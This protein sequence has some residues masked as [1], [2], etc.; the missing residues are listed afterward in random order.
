MVGGPS[1]TVTALSIRGNRKSINM[2]N[3]KLDKLFGLLHLSPEEERKKRAIL[4]RDMR[5]PA[6]LIGV[7]Q[8]G[9]G[10]T[11]LLRSIFRI[12]D[13]HLER[14]KDFKTNPVV[15]ET[16]VFRSFTI[17]TPEGFL[18]QFTDGPGL[19][20]SEEMD[21]H[22]IPMWIKEIP[23]HD[24]VYWVLDGASRDMRHIQQNMKRI[25]D[26][27]NYHTRVVVVLNKVDNIELDEEDDADNDGGWSREFNFPTEAL[28]AL[29]KARTD[30]VIKKL[31]K[32]VKISEEQ[33]VV[34][35]ARRRWNHGP[36]L[37]KLIERLPAEKRIKV[38]RARDVKDPRELMNPEALREIEEMRKQEREGR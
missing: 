15:S 4:E 6:K 38:S 34:C 2:Q 23:K 3:D 13:E 1:N 17:P 29:I 28:E 19:G 25:L 30:D 16:R 26:A 33:M 10:K 27:T 31:A 11:T 21:D 37:D 12:G 5:K 8:T 20:E 7:G 9:V 14:I 32:Y 35:S 24:L 22:Y 18:V 36:V